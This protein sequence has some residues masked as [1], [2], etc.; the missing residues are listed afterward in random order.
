MFAHTNPIPT[1][2]HPDS[3]SNANKL[4]RLIYHWWSFH[5]YFRMS[6]EAGGPAVD[7][8]TN[9]VSGSAGNWWKV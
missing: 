1:F 4:Q 8:A 7:F 2:P 3:L 6:F 5:L 9:Y